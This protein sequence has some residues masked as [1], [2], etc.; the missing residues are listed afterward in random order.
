MARNALYCRALA[1]IAGVDVIPSADATGTAAG[2]AMLFGGEAP[3]A[4]QPEPVAPMT[5]DAFS[6]YCAAWRAAAG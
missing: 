2:A 5:G 1:A 6:A 3:P 4:K